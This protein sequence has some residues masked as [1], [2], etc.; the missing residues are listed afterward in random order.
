MIGVNILASE[1]N[2]EGREILLQRER[3][4]RKGAKGDELYVSEKD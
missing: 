1:I 2:D 3:M 4:R